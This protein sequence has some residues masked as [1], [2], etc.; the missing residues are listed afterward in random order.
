MVPEHLAMTSSC[1]DEGG[2]QQWLCFILRFYKLAA[3][4]EGANKSVSNTFLLIR[5]LTPMISANILSKLGIAKTS[6]DSTNVLKFCS[7][8]DICALRSNF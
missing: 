7:H 1:R 8:V 2:T 3:V 4:A 6:Y 5:Q